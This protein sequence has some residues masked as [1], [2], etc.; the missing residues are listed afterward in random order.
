[1]SVF[2]RR[3]KILAAFFLVSAGFAYGDKVIFDTGIYTTTFDFSGYD[4]ISN[5]KVK[6]VDDLLSSYKNARETGGLLALFSKDS[7]KKLGAIL[8]DEIKHKAY[9]DS[10]SNIES[11]KVLLSFT[12]ENSVALIVEIRMKGGRVFYQANHLVREDLSLKIDFRQIDSNSPIAVLVDTLNRNVGK[13]DSLKI[14][15]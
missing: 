7:Q 1:M 12:K 13:A 14:V 4:V 8:E 2:K 9:F 6:E 5:P 11:M 10:I 3:F 15:K